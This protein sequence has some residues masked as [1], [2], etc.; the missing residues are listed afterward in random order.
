MKIYIDADYK[1][2]TKAGEG[3]TEVETTAFDGKCTTFIEGYRFVP[4]GKAWIRSDGKVFNG[5]MVSPYKPLEP[6]L[7]AQTEY[8]LEESQQENIEL[9]GMLADVADQEY[10]KA[11]EEIN[12]V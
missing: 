12:N 8:E 1:C 10:T 4:R 7:K 2:Y 9:V 3:L 11:M 5:E 6:L